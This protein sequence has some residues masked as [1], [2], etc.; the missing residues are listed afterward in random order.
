[1]WH[2]K[3]S[4]LNIKIPLKCEHCKTIV[5]CIETARPEVL[6]CARF[7]FVLV[8]YSGNVSQMTLDLKDQLWFCG[9]KWSILVV[10]LF[11]VKYLRA[12]AAAAVSL[13]FQ[14]IWPSFLKEA[15]MMLS[16]RCLDLYQTH[17]LH[18]NSCSFFLESQHPSDPDVLFLSASRS[19]AAKSTSVPSQ[20]GSAPPPVWRR[21]CWPWTWVWLGSWRAWPP[22]EAC[23]APHLP[24]LRRRRWGCGCWRC[25]PSRPASAAAAAPPSPP[26]PTGILGRCC[27]G[28]Q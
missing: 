21:L 13:Q 23:V 20:L 24:P 22:L 4:M 7:R 1:M 16:L 19:R 12:A 25:P 5:K 26:P 17:V 14:K 18:L 11:N 3:V 27:W 8:C 15:K 28:S 10:F 9:G 2:H 6:V